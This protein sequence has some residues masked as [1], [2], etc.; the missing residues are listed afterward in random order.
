MTWVVSSLVENPWGI[1]LNAETNFSSVD[2][3]PFVDFRVNNGGGGISVRVYSGTNDY[4]GLGSWDRKLDVSY[5][6]V[7][8]DYIRRTYNLPDDHYVEVHGNPRD[9]GNPRFFSSGVLEE[10]DTEEEALEFANNEVDDLDDGVT[11]RNGSAV[12]VA[13]FQEEVNGVFISRDIDLIYTGETIKLYLLDD[14]INFYATILETTAD[15]FTYYYDHI[16]LEDGSGTPRDEAAEF[17]P[18]T[19]CTPRSIVSVVNIE[20]TGGPADIIYIQPDFTPQIPDTNNVTITVVDGD[21]VVSSTMI[22]NGDGSVTI[23]DNGNILML[24]DG[25]TF[26]LNEFGNVGFYANGD[27]SLTADNQVQLGVGQNSVTVE[28]GSL[29]IR[30]ETGSATL[31]AEDINRLKELL[32]E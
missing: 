22:E 32:G 25:G 9:N 12:I 5:V 13:S 15:S 24:N 4:A 31:T 30:D 7:A 16:N 17:W 8:Q 10:F 14:I 27:A 21:P 19:G 6:S 26:F 28:N 1:C 2:Y 23:S 29:T 11:F 18:G 20:D 3:K